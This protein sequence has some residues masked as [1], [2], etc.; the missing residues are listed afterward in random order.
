MCSGKPIPGS[1]V[2]I[3]AKQD[4]YNG[5]QREKR[6]NCRHLGNNGLCFPFLGWQGEQGGFLLPQLHGL[7]EKHPLAFSF[8]VKLVF[9]RQ[10]QGWRDRD[11][12]THR[13]RVSGR[14][15]VRQKETK[16]EKVTET[17]RLRKGSAEEQEKVDR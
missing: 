14:D 16:A 12:E 9:M 15:W 4:V 2:S 8:S 7:S 10:R 1:I 13:D 5:K 17:D 11:K 3:K 6:K